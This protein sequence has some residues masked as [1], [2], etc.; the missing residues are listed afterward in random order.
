M[1]TDY[2]CKM[3]RPT[4][5]VATA[6][7]LIQNTKLTYQQIAD[8]CGMYVHDIEKLQDNT[9]ITARNPIEF[10]YILKEDIIK[11]ENNSFN[12]LKIRKN[13]KTKKSKKTKYTFI[14]KKSK[15]SNCTA[16]M[17]KNCP[18]ASNSDIAKFLGSSSSTVKKIRES[19]ENII[20]EHPVSSGLCS[21]QEFDEFMSNHGHNITHD[22]DPFDI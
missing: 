6:V 8:F 2:F 22:H 13:S 20:I 4:M 11:C 16:W 15:K 14:S 10:E 7:W 17:C 18:S 5:P 9:S 21:Q 1:Y 12:S 19:L 3:N